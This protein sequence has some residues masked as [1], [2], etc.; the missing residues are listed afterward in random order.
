MKLFIGWSGE[1]S[2]VVAYRLA[3]WLPSIVPNLQP[4]FSPQILGG[5][6]W[7]NVVAKELNEAEYGILCITKENMNTQW[8]NF[9][10]GALWKGIGDTP[11][12]P[13]LIDNSST[14]LRGPLDVFQSK[15]L[16]EKEI[17]DLCRLLA[18][19]TNLD[20]R[21]VDINFEGIWPNLIRDITYDLKLIEETTKNT[22]RA[23]LEEDKTYGIKILKPEDNARVTKTFIITII[24]KIKPPDEV[25]WILEYDPDNYQYW[26]KKP[27]RFS[28]K[29][30]EWS[31]EISIGGKEG[32][33]REIKVILVG[34]EGK[35][36]INYSRKVFR[37]IHKETD[38]WPGIENLTSDIVTCDSITVIRNEANP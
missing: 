17:R 18:I 5:A 26:P 32:R 36:L 20:A 9:E 4:F 37:E 35:A 10:A 19:K 25:A 11:V 24:C 6:N 23:E 1:K 16:D 21:R 14:E 13:L 29:S 8:I 2:K 30:N 3:E 38:I 33:P 28:D 15:T 31:T 27:I 22:S 7:L 12:C 34:N